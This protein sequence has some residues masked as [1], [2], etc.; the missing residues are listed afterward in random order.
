MNAEQ[1]EWTERRTRAIATE[2]GLPM[3]D[4]VEHHESSIV[5]LWHDLKLA[6]EID[7]IPDGPPPPFDPYDLDLPRR[8]DGS[9]SDEEPEDAEQETYPPF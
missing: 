2:A 8:E 9:A 1:R 4:E 7:E 6:V 5:L 3:P